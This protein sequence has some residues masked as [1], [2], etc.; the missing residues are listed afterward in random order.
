MC[1]ILIVCVCAKLLQLCPIFCKPMQPYSP[2]GSSARG[3]LQTRT[4]EW[5]AVS[6]SRGAFR[7]RDGTGISYVSC[8]G[9]WVLYHQR[10]L[11]RAIQQ[12]GKC[13]DR[14]REG[15]MSC[16][17]ELGQ[18]SVLSVTEMEGDNAPKRKL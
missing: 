17:K 14:E 18:V 9:R 1:Q 11:G 4:L 7:A 3:I 2:P 6:S 10:Y 12:R 8:I 15:E 13:R 16:F 5:V